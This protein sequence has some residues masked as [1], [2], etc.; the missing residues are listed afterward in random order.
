MNLYIV[1]DSALIQQRLIQFIEE[2][3]GIH[4]VGVAGDISHALQ[5]I[6]DEHAD[7]MILDIQLADGNGLQLLK[8]IKQSKPEIK[9]VVLTNHATEDNRVHAMRAGADGFLDKS[10]DFGLLQNY[11]LRWQHPNSNHQIN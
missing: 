7:A 5:G 11:L 4:V 3:P 1:E 8:N 6:L 9:V 10:T 2:V